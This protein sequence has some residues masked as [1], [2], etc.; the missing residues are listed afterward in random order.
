MKQTCNRRRKMGDK[1]QKS[2]ETHTTP[3]TIYKTRVIPSAERGISQQVRSSRATPRVRFLL[4]RNDT[5]WVGDFRL[6]KAP[7]FVALL[8]LFISACKLPQVATN[9]R[10]NNVPSAYRNGNTTDTTNSATLRPRD[11]FSDPLLVSLLDSAVQNNQELNISLAE[12]IITRAEVQIRQ[13]DFLPNVRAQAGAGVEHTPRYTRLGALEEAIP[14]D[15]AREN[16]K[17]FPDFQI[18]LVANWEVDIWRKLRNARKSAFTRYFASQEGRRFVITNVVAEV[19]NS[20]YELEALDNQL[21]I[22]QQNISI[23]NNALGIVRQQKEAGRTTELA[24]QRFEAEVLH[25]QSRQYALRQGIVETENRINFL[26][27]R[28]PQPIARGTL[29]LDSTLPNS[30]VFTGIPAQLLQNR[31]D[32]RRA[33]LEVAASKLDVKVARALFYPRLDIRAALGFQA[34]NPKFLFTT[35]ESILGNL[36]GDLTAPL[37]NRLAIKAAYITA[38]ARQVSAAYNYERTVLNA[39]IE[40]ANQQA[41]IG[42]MGSS[43]AIRSQQVAA[44]L[45]S[46]T[47]ATSLFQSGR[48]DYMDVLLTQ[49]DALEARLELAETR[50]DQLGATVDIYRAL[51]GGWR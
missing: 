38:N 29:S 48:A 6:A 2:M 3:S 20:Y 34:F 30:A 44:L 36:A 21:A 40:V 22:T 13:G 49:R 8:L 27:G 1:R 51:G 45:R 43:F 33:E 26:L 4:R 25:T 24:V 41:R 15:P 46:I 9:V 5:R 39:Y 19:A 12:I 7:A 47:L 42:N 37:V 23:L 35:P 10:H 18:G 17:L 16:P 50:R 31:P 32:I 28:F 11:F 14:V